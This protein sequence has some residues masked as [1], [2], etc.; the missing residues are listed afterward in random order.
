MSDPALELWLVRHGE[1]THSRD[2]LLAGW[3][4]VPLTDAGVAQAAAV[5]PLLAAE[6]FDSVW[7][8]DLSR[9]VRTAELAWGEARRDPRL[10]EI[11][12]GRLEGLPWVTLEDPLKQALIS[13]SGFAPPGGETIEAMRDRVHS[14]LAELTPGRH[15]LFTHGGVIRALTREVGEDSFLPTGSVVGL[16]WTARTLS[17]VRTQDGARPPFVAPSRRA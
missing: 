10:R 15:L 12:F 8:S 13:F 7:C 5:A 2:G 4:D 14:F 17:F 11:N 16:D 6:R 1:T 9:A 3:V